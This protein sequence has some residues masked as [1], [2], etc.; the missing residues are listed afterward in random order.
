MAKPSPGPAPSPRG[1][2]AWE[3]TTFAKARNSVAISLQSV[4]SHPRL[5]RPAETIPSKASLSCRAVRSSMRV[6]SVALEEPSGG[7]QGRLVRSGRFFRCRQDL[8]LVPLRKAYGARRL[9]HR[10]LVDRRT[11]SRWNARVR[12]PRC[13]SLLFHST[14]RRLLIHCVSSLSS[15]AWASRRMRTRVPRQPPRVGSRHQG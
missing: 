10:R 6:S 11:S 13:T 15:R 7:L 5:A 1:G 8:G 2:M 9:R 14:S 4:P 12:C 3:A